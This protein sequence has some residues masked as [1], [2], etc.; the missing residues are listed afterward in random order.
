MN[1]KSL[2]KAGREEKIS[3]LAEKLL[4]CLSKYKRSRKRKL[5]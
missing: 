3:V 5:A 4:P 1:K 2:I